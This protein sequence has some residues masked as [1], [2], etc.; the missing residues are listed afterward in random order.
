MI[1]INH[2]QSL[3]KNLIKSWN[4]FINFV[5]T[6]GLKKSINRL[7]QSKLIATSIQSPK[8]LKIFLFSV[9]RFVRRRRGGRHCHQDQ[10]SCRKISLTSVSVKNLFF[11]QVLHSKQTTVWLN[12]ICLSVKIYHQKKSKTKK[13]YIRRAA[14]TF[15]ITL[16]KAYWKN[17][18]K[19]IRNV[20][21]IKEPSKDAKN[22][23]FPLYFC[24]QQIK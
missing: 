15:F 2:F 20:L 6:F 21:S 23:I 4:N 8:C 14:F 22:L 5:V 13:H 18:L 16:L 19:I 7:F 1:I 3:F 12:I 24:I 9:H 10:H 17:Q 11:Q